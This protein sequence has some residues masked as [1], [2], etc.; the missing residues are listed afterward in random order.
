[1]LWSGL[2]YTILGLVNPLLAS[3][4]DW[5]WFIASQVAFGVVAGLVVVRQS[6]IPTRENVSFALRAGIEAPGI[7][8]PRGSERERR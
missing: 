4:I 8:P 7:T 2:L 5:F 1:V 3:H 6:T